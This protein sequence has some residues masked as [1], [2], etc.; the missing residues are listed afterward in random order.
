[1]LEFKPWSSARGAP[2][3]KGSSLQPLVNG[4]KPTL[5]LQ[6]FSSLIVDPVG[7]AQSL[8][9]LKVMLG[10]KMAHTGSLTQMPSVQ[11]KKTKNK[12]N[13]LCG[14]KVSSKVRVPE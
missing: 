12:T 14:I 4:N 11:K 7:G 5:L 9:I 8:E 13:L 10:G 2:A 1:M 3:L 6:L